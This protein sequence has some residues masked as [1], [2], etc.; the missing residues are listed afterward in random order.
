MPTHLSSSDVVTMR[1]SLGVAPNLPTNQVRQLLDECE[2]L[3]RL[4]SEVEAIVVKMRAP[5]GDVRTTLN[6]LAKLV[7]RE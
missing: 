3:L 6:D 2:R 7:G 1:R 4:E 5:F